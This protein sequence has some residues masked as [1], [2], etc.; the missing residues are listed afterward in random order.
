MPWP[1]FIFFQTS[2]IYKHMSITKHT[3]ARCKLLDN[4]LSDSRGYTLDE[5]TEKVKDA[6]CAVSR[7]TIEYNISYI[8]NELLKN[9][10]VKIERFTKNRKRYLRYNPKGY[11]V[12]N[13]FFTD[14]EKHMLSE[15]MSL[16][17]RFDGI[18][19]LLSLDKL[20]S[21]LEIE[22]S[23]NIIS[24]TKSSTAN[25]NILAKLFAIISKKQVVQIRYKKFQS[26]DS[27]YVILHPYLLKEY[28]R[29]W[30]L[31]GAGNKDGLI[32]NFPIDRIVQCVAMET[33]KYIPY[34]GD[35]NAIF[36]N[37]IGVTYKNGA[38][39]RKIDFWVSRKNYDYISTKPIHKTQKML[40][41]SAAL[42]QKYAPL[43]G[44]GEFLSIECQDNYELIRE[45]ASFGDE[46][47]VISPC[48]IQ[49]KVFA[50][51][52]NLSEK[53]LKLRK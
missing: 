24:L 13:K 41:N 18:P 6:D 31:F 16:L 15:V 8:E 30:F 21:S 45:L 23:P 17:G 10:G 12:F 46:L 20:R 14:Y 49:D 51:I 34:D 44:D 22:N 1:H 29:R 35:I 52:N 40:D 9:T 43:L 19:N 28:N 50:F 3:L 2:N 11:S 5:L 25:S 47:V 38:E 53:Y 33:R 7:R 26:S 42:S 36:D 27:I 48:D 39:V 37:I 32:L 4:L